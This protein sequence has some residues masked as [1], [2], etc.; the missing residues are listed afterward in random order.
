MCY[1]LYVLSLTNMCFL[2]FSILKI[3]D[4]AFS[5]YIRPRAHSILAAANIEDK[6]DVKSLASESEWLFEKVVIKPGF[7]KETITMSVSALLFLPE[8]RLNRQAQTLVHHSGAI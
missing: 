1:F 2:Y 4:A 6:R 7:L 5:Y 8:P 3:S